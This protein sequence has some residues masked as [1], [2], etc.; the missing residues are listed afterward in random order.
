MQVVLR[1][2]PCCYLLALYFDLYMSSLW[3]WKHLENRSIPEVDALCLSRVTHSKQKTMSTVF[4]FHL[5]VSNHLFQIPK[6]WC[7]K[8]N[9]SLKWAYLQIHWRLDWP[10]PMWPLRHSTVETLV[11]TDRIRCIWAHCAYRHCCASYSCSFFRDSLVGELS[12]IE[13]CKIK[14]GLHLI[15]EGVKYDFKICPSRSRLGG[16]R[17]QTSSCM[18]ITIIICPMRYEK[19]NRAWTWLPLIKNLKQGLNQLWKN[20]AESA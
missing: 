14:S 11:Q 12:T 8:C 19:Q 10:W 17:E 18:A 7:K 2:S 15:I 5:L 16:E 20:T 4:F 6:H 9:L 1:G 3:R 13:C